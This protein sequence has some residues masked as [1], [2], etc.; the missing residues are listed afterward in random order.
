[1]NRDFSAINAVHDTLYKFKDV[2]EQYVIK[3]GKVYMLEEFHKILAEI[4]KLRL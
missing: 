2:N 1:M 3:I 4:S